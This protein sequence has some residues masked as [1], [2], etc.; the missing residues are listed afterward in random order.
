MV[1]KSTKRVCVLGSGASGLC[2]ARHAVD[3]GYDVTV[4]EQQ[5]SLGGT[6]LYSPQINSFS[7]LYE[8]MFTNL[9]KQIMSFEHLPLDT[10]GPESFIHHRE[11][12]A[13]LERYAKP[14]RQLIKF[15][16]VVT[17]IQR[18][19]AEWLVTVKPV[20]AP[21]TNGQT[22]GAINDQLTK[23]ETF[24][25]DILFVCNG[26]FSQPK[27]PIFADKLKLPWLHCHNY[28]RPHGY[29]N[30][31]IVVV[32]AGPSGVDVAM[33]VYMLHN[34]EHK[35]GLPNN[36]EENARLVG[37]DED[38]R[39]LL[40]ENGEHLDEIDAV[41]FCTGYVYETPFCD[42]DIIEIKEK[43]RYL[44]PLYLHCIHTQYPTSLF[45]IG[46]CWNLIPFVCFDHQVNYALA[47]VDGTAQVPSS[48]EMAR[49]EDDRL[50]YLKENGKPPSSFHGLANTQWCYFNLLAKLANRPCLPPVIEKIY[51]H[52]HDQRTTNLA[53]FI[54]YHLERA[55]GPEFSQIT[56]DLF[57]YRVNNVVLK[58]RVDLDK[59]K[60]ETLDENL[61]ENLYGCS[62]RIVGNRFITYQWSSSREF[63]HFDLYHINNIHSSL[64]SFR[65]K[66]EPPNFFNFFHIFEDK[67]YFFSKFDQRNR[68]AD[69]NILNLGGLH[70]YDLKSGEKETYSTTALPI[71][72]YS[73]PA[74]II[75]L[76][77]LFI[78]KAFWL[79][80]KLY[81]RVKE[82][83]NNCPF[84]HLIVLDILTLQWR[85]IAD[86]NI[87]MKLSALVDE[88]GMLNLINMDNKEQVYYRIGLNPINTI[89]TKWIPV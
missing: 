6:W 69:P 83:E 27:I 42:K 10:A 82:V 3:A 8:K 57:I 77:R 80:S 30:K 40:L 18:E 43:G 66:A 15:S 84:Y 28:R 78:Q 2:A 36:V 64:Q 46:L 70:V 26:H 48:D 17:K 76:Q 58:I 55:Y 63:I 16:T 51:D 68:N 74:N 12:L 35:F 38:G 47:L 20:Q 5:Q 86:A 52:V 7:S 73:P 14:I 39:T 79:D 81:V 44:S 34:R 67:L 59:R 65:L 75:R 9:P 25:F 33:Q 89:I 49:F 61:I 50:R 41:I 85:L 24:T 54:P 53:T 71:F 4:F 1:V 88:N 87:E 62:E 72:H 19:G 29:T 13:Y 22:N 56:N 37:V 32:G 21:L 23:T 11:V 31:N 60:M 45:F